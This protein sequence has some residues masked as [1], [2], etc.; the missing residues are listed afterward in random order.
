VSVQSLGN[1]SLEID[2]ERCHIYPFPARPLLSET[3]ATVKVFL[4]VRE[5]NKERARTGV[6]DSE[7]EEESESDERWREAI[8]NVT[9]QFS[10]WYSHMVIL[11]TYHESMNLQHLRQ[12]FPNN[13]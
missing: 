11:G 9:S 12:S 6:R 4:F 1:A 13:T 2:A 7:G 3:H 10:T 8:D 5:I